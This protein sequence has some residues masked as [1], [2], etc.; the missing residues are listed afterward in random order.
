MGATPTEYDAVIS[1]LEAQIV[2]LQGTIDLLK[3]QRDKGSPPSGPGG[4]GSTDMP[5]RTATT[6]VTAGSGAISRTPVPLSD[7]FFSMGIVDAVK[8]YLGGV[9]RP[10]GTK[11]LVWALEAGGFH[12]ESKNFYGTLFSV[13]RRRA[14]TEGDIV[15][16]KGEWA[17]AEWYPGRR[18]PGQ[19]KVQP[20][21]ETGQELKDRKSEAAEG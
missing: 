11:T 13:L 1:D 3:R 4:P 17:L 16:V 7:A 5:D 18:R 12:S 19:V 6:S 9:R 14:N 21:D 8:K 2:E 20:L 10:V 15:K